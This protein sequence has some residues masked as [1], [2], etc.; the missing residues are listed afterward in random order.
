MF[1]VL[2]PAGDGVWSPQ[3]FLFS[4]WN[5]WF[6]SSGVKTQ[7]N[8]CA[9]RQISLLHAH[10]CGRPYSVKKSWVLCRVIA[11]RSSV[12]LCTSSSVGLHQSSWGSNLDCFEELSHRPHRCSKYDINLFLLPPKFALSLKYQA[13][14]QHW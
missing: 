3:R 2:L 14:G 10:W 11:R 4:R 9:W 13:C 8:D 7:V 1:L 6:L 5:S 12:G